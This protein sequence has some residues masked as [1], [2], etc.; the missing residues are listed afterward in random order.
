MS[1]PVSDAISEAGDI[2]RRHYVYARVELTGPR[3]QGRRNPWTHGRTPAEWARELVLGVVDSATFPRGGSSW[4]L[5]DGHAVYHGTSGDAGSE[6]DPGRWTYSGWFADPRDT[7]RW[8]DERIVPLRE[9]TD[10]ALQDLPD[11]FAEAL[12]EA[13]PAAEDA[14][15]EV[16]WYRAARQQDDRAQRIMLHVR[17]FER[18]LP[19]Q[20]DDR[21]NDAVRHYFRSHWAID[22]FSIHAAGL[23]AICK[24]L[25][26]DLD[27]AHRPSERF[28]FSQKRDHFII[29]C[30]ALLDATSVIASRVPSDRP[31]WRQQIRTLARWADHP[32][33]AKE[34]L[35]QLEHEFDILLKRALRQR[36]AVVHGIKPVPAVVATIDR[37]LARLSAYVVNDALQR[38][39]TGED[40]GVRF[41]RH[42]TIAQRRIW[43]LDE[44]GATTRY[45]LYGAI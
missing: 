15:A 23:A 24:Q 6:A 33:K 30:G 3:A 25:V 12:A 11:G 28:F 20:G 10:M 41:E 44:P 38:V 35:Q 2:R 29:N 43:R 4:R 36:N 39:G 9:G 16:R 18:S 7:A 8:S 17:A 21:W 31:L 40:L 42:R 5:L 13:N 19:L 1:E 32:G 27:P 14:L 45:A 37:F 34:H 26:D 22:Q